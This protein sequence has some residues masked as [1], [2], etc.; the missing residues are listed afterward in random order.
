MT[1]FKPQISDVGSDHSTNL[2]TTTAAQ[3]VKLI[4][5]KRF[6]SNYFCRLRSFALLCSRLEKVLWQESNKST[7]SV[8]HG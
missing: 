1:G 4:P 8:F 2:A 6:S 5:L 3:F 7:Y